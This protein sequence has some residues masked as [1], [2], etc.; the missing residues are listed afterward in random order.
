ME[1]EALEKNLERQLG[2]VRASETRLSLVLPLATALF[3]SIAVKIGGL[4][5]KDQFEIA[6]SVVA[7]GCVSKVVEIDFRHL[8][9]G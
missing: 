1:I 9:A 3:G 8:R 4:T 5:G 6:V 2:W 7:L